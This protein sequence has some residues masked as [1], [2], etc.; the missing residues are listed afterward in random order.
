MNIHETFHFDKEGEVIKY[1]RFRKYFLTIILI[2]VAIL[3]FGVGR[4]TGESREGVKIITNDQDLMTKAQLDLKPSD[5]GASTENSVFASS[6]GTKYYYSH[7][8]STVS[9][10][11]KVTF[12]SALM[13]EKA[14]YAL[15]TN[16]KPR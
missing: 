5:L 11:N 12:A 13:A 1:P 2:L 8:K 6:Q 7:C 9:E 10:K 3:A 4:L 16:C 14:G 15:A